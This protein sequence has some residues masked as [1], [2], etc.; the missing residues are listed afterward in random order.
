[1]S[2]VPTR[3]ASSAPTAAL[4]ADLVSRVTLLATV[5]A[6]AAAILVDVRP[7]PPRAHRVAPA[8]A[9]V[10]LRVAPIPIGPTANSTVMVITFSTQNCAQAG[11][12]GPRPLPHMNLNVSERE[13][14]V[15]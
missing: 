2:A 4:D 8:A 5:F 14:F 13:G 3:A 10:A 1:M 7:T 15:Y 12:Q 11:S 9:L 6:L